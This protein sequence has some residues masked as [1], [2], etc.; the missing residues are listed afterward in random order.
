MAPDNC[1]SMSRKKPRKQMLLTVPK[2]DLPPRKSERTREAIFDSALEFL[3]TRPF[4]D[5]TVAELMSEA[6]C[7]PTGV[8]SVLQGSSRTDGDSVARTQGRRFLK[9]RRLGFKVRAIPFP[10]LVES[11]Q[12]LVQ[13]CYQRGPI[14]RAVA[15]AA[16]NDEQLEKSWLQYLKD[17]DDA[18][19][20]RIEKQQKAGWV[21][22]FDAHTTAVALNRM[23][24]ALVIHAFGRRPRG[25]SRPVLDAMLRIW[26]STL[27]PTRNSV[28]L[29]LDGR[30]H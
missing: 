18:V 8:L 23:D 17:F 7:K 15:D 19:T 4:R 28:E 9:P 27:Y 12:A 5:L 24:A 22:E 13:V 1:Y 3:W 10:L 2:P 29:R 21:P 6:G 30:R 26:S 16:P 14:L 11:L 25:Q 20:A